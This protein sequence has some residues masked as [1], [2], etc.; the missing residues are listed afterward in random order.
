MPPRRGGRPKPLGTLAA[1]AGQ[2][3]RVSHGSFVFATPSFGFVSL[4]GLDPTPRGQT[5]VAMTSRYIHVLP[6]RQDPSLC[7][8]TVT[9]HGPHG[10]PWPP[11]LRCRIAPYGQ[12]TLG[13]A[14]LGLCTTHTVSV[15]HKNYLFWTK[16]DSNIKNATKWV[17]VAPFAFGAFGVGGWSHEPPRAIGTPPGPILGQQKCSP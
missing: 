9:T 6:Y 11:L 15:Q 1:P 16:V 12:I 17:A 2:L 13:G 3:G 5:C 7:C 14:P 4:S 10:S 8:H